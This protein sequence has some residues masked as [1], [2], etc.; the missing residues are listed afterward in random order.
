M[1]DLQISVVVLTQQLHEAQDGLH[2]SD[3]NAH[4]ALFL[5]LIS[6]WDRR[7]IGCSLVLFGF[8][9]TTISCVSLLGDR[10]GLN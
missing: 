8:S 7:A 2:D 1:A 3:G 4:L 6:S 9:L 10:R 5:A